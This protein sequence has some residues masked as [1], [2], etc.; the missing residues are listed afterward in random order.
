MEKN[1]IYES[2][3]KKKQYQSLFYYFSYFVFFRE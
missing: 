2:D 1:K 3:S